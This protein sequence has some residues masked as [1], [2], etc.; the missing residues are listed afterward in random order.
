MERAMVSFRSGRDLVRSDLV[1]LGEDGPY[2]LTIRHSHGVIVEY[3]HTTA[4]ALQRQEVLEGILSAVQFHGIAHAREGTMQ[5]LGRGTRDS[6]A[7]ANRQET[8]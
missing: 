5:S 1:T 7:F 8:P 4:A 6:C 3:F 2:R